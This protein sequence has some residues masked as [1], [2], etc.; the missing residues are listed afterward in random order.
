MSEP[1][2][3]EK[4]EMYD[5]VS[6]VDL[7]PV[8]RLMCLPCHTAFLIQVTENKEICYCPHCG[9]SIDGSDEEDDDDEEYFEEV[10]EH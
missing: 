4:E 1:S 5:F 8:I 6:R 2:D 9:S 10:S 7:G 3:E